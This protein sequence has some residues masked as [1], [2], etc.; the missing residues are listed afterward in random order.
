MIYLIGISGVGKTTI[1]KLLAN[2]LDYDFI[3]LD[4]RIEV[5]F[6]RS[7]GELF[8]CGETYFRECES[9][10]LRTLPICERTVV[11]TGGGVVLRKT[12]IRHMRQS[13]SVILLHRSLNAILQSLDSEDR[14]LLNGRP[15]RLYKLYRARQCAYLHAAD[16][17][18][19]A[20][21]PARAVKKIVRSL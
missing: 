17:R 18:I 10:A 3:D 1:G 6:G 19:I 5:L 12:N 9:A 14:P 21:R 8:E 13:G 20:R 11:A 7:V 15:N 4:S 16:R 2:R